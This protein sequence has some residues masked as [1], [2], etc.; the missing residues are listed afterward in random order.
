MFPV[1]GATDLPLVRPGCAHHPFII[2]AGDH[3]RHFSV[4]VFIP[5]P[6]VE[7]LETPGQYNRADLD[8]Y[9]VRPLVEIDRAVLADI[10]AYTTF[11]FL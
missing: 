5:H 9:L 4:A 1:G 2:E 8:I 10:L 11:L 7:R 3:V 6:G